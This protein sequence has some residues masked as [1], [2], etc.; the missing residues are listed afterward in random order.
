MLS[1]MTPMERWIIAMEATQSPVGEVKMSL[2]P[3]KIG[4]NG[5]WLMVMALVG[6]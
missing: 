4:P 3:G 2:I 5:G 1:A 6:I